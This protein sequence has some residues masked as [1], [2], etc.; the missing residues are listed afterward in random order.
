M[1]GTRSNRGRNKVSLDQSSLRSKQRKIQQV[2]LQ[3][4]FK[5]FYQ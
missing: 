5:K 3:I 1:E 2:N 4:K